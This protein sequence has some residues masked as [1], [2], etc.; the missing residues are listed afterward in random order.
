MK[1][2]LCFFLVSVFYWFIPQ[3]SDLIKV[4]YLCQSLR[5][6]NDFDSLDSTAAINLSQTI[7]RFVEDV[8]FA[9]LD[10]FVFLDLEFSQQLKNDFRSLLQVFF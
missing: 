6:S 7:Y 3:V 10:L 8:A 1:E 4:R 2:A 9:D 5:L